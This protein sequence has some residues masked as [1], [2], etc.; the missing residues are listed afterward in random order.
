MRGLPVL[1]EC[2]AVVRRHHR[3]Q[4]LV[5]AACGQPVHQPVQLGVRE[6]DLAVVRIFVSR[7]EGF[8]RCVRRVGVVEVEARRATAR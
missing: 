1:P 2:F 7:G 8:G 6:R 3:E 4:P 5:Q